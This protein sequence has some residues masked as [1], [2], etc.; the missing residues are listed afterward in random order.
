MNAEVQKAIFLA[1]TAASISSVT[2]IRDTPIVAPTAANFPFIELGASQAL[3]EDAGGDTGLEEYFDIHT[4]SRT[5]GKLQ[6]KQIMT[7]IYNALHGQT[8][9]VTGRATAHCWLDS[10]RILEAPD[11]LT[12]H[13]LQTF[14][15]IHR[16]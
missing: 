7:A 8:L 4:W 14:R 5:A 1:L 12:R 16:A 9:T 2:Q 10:A 6:T 11:G 3:P 13:G 15:I